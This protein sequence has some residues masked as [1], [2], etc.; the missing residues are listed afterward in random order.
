MPVSL[1]QGWLTT[2]S[3]PQV[4]PKRPWALGL[5]AEGPH[6]RVPGHVDAGV[7]VLRPAAR[8]LVAKGSRAE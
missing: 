7:R 2:R 1:S 3:W 5:T 8:A 6:D 4:W